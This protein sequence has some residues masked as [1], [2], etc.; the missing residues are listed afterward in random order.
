MI[1]HLG[2]GSNLFGPEKQL[3][4]ALHAIAALDGV[5]VVRTSQSIITPPYGY[6]DQP[7]FCNQV[8]EIESQIPPVELLKRLLDIE[9]QMGRQRVIKWGPRVIDIDILLAEDLVMDN[10][11]V[12]AREGIPE[13]VIPH[14]DLQNRLFVLQPL[15]ELIPDAVHP[16]LHKTI[17]EL[18]YAL[19][20]NGGN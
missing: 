14:P 8:L 5:R 9:L 2:L 17:K 16:V 11:D 7:D 15:L 18:Y 4:T 1:I 13:L 3:D 10:R 20:E 19:I 12:A 6:P